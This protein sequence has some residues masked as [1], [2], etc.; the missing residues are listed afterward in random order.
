LFFHSKENFMNQV[1]DLHVEKKI[2]QLYAENSAAQFFF[3]WCADRVRDARETKI[4]RIMAI[5]GISRSEAVN[6]AK[7]L[8][9]AGCGDFV[10]GRRGS[11]SRF[12]WKHSRISLGRVAQGDADE[13][14]D[15]V[16]PVDE[17]EEPILPYETELSHQGLTIAQAKALLAN[18]LGVEASQIE[19]NI[20]A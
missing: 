18:S 9:E 7:K 5:A 12:A 4:E 8:E 11:P 17:D 15:W 10:V 6:L 14:E 3:D 2:R 13:I 16:N 1:I 20:R 19:I